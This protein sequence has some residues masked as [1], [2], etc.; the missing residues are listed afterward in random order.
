[1]VS[2]FIGAAFPWIMLGLFVA[3]SCSTMSKKEK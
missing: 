1:M 3:V 2:D